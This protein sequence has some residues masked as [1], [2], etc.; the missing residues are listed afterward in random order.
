MTSV[1]VGAIASLD[2][3]TQTEA[4]HVLCASARLVG[5][6]TLLRLDPLSGPGE[7]SVPSL[8]RCCLMK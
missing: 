4:V 1:A 5:A 6:T 2:C 8:R 7:W 3:S